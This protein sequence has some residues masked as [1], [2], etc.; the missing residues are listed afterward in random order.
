MGS[1][2][3]DF[4]AEEGGMGR[5]EE[6]SGPWGIRREAWEVRGIWQVRLGGQWASGPERS[7]EE[8]G[9]GL[10]ASNV[11]K[12]ARLYPELIFTFLELTNP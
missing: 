4:Q 7:W 11:K 12:G 3:R 8:E 2:S 10:G 1:H 6:Q 9:H 5:R